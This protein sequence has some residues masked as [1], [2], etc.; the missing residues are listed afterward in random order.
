MSETIA[1]QQSIQKKRPVR[2]L[3]VATYSPPEDP[4]EWR[5]FYSLNLPPYYGSIVSLKI[6]VFKF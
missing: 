1:Q 6:H 3:M 4:Q 5:Q 2:V